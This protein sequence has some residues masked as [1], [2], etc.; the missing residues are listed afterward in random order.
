MHELG[1]LRMAAR[2]VCHAAEKNHIQHVK[3]VTLEI[4]DQSGFVPLFFE[5][6]FPIIRQ[7]FPALQKAELK[8]ETVPGG[9]QLLVKDFGY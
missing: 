3:H 6:Y 5:K 8:M 9:R 2:T 4:G 1:V 7:E